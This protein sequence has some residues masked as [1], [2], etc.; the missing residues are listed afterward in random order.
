MDGEWGM[1]MD[2][3]YL[4]VASVCGRWIFVDRESLWTANIHGLQTTDSK[5]LWTRSGYGR[6]I[7]LDGEWLWMANGT[8]YMRYLLGSGM[9]Q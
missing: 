4:W 1:F 2:G 7:T 8:K 6:R 5:Y 9:V 3:E